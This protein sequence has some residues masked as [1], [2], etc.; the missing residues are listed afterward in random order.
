MHDFDGKNYR[1]YHCAPSQLPHVRIF[2]PQ[3][4]P[5]QSLSSS[6]QEVALSYLP[7][8]FLRVVPVFLLKRK[9]SSVKLMMMMTITMTITIPTERDSSVPTEIEPFV[10]LVY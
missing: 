8:F 5:S 3:I 4:C 2:G 10:M 1:G 7:F 6:L 9:F